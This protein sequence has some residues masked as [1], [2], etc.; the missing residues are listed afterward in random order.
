MKKPIVLF[1]ALVFAL[2]LVTMTTTSCES[3]GYQSSRPEYGA[4]GTTKKMK[5]A[6]KKIVRGH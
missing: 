3:S 1:I 2:P 5:Y 6:R 4:Y